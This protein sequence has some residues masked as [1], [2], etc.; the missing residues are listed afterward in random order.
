MALSIVTNVSAMMV[1]NNLNSATDSMTQALERMT[2]GYKVN[3]AKDDAA[4]YNIIDSMSSKI[5][6]FE[7]A[8]DNAQIGIDMLTTTEENYALITDH[9]SRIRDLTEQAANGTYSTESLVAIN[10]EI[11]ARLNEIDR[12]ART[13][14]YNGMYLMTD[15]GNTQ[16]QDDIR[17]QVGIYG[18]ASSG[19]TL[20]SELFDDATIAQILGTKNGAP[21]TDVEDLAKAFSGV[22]V[23]DPANPTK[24]TTNPSEFLSVIDAAITDIASRITDLGA[25]QNRLES[26]IS[27]IDTNVMQ[28]TNSRG[29]MRDADI[30]EESTSY[31]SAQILQSAAST[32]LA[33]AN[34][35]PSV[36]VQLI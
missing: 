13:A 19:V 14:E 31:I 10:A 33:T 12:V 2:T 28:L 6:S 23:A 34:Q 1:R 21:G 4:G 17:I 18:D 27:A 22:D 24:E 30:A 25:A 20:E 7:V 3:N 9:L 32:L 35:M 26:A 29:T 5:G 15:D 36:A 11:T 8:G 16:I